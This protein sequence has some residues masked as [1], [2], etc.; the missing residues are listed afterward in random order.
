MSREGWGV[1]FE[2]GQPRRCGLWKKNELV[3]VEKTFE[4]GEMTEFVY[5]LPEDGLSSPR[6]SYMGEYLDDLTLHFPRH[7]KGRLVNPASGIVCWYG[8]FDKGKQVEGR[9]CDTDGWYMT[10]PSKN[11]SVSIDSIPDLLFAFTFVEKLRICNHS[12]NDCT[13]SMLDLSSSTFLKEV[14]IGDHCF[15]HTKVFKA[16]NNQFIQTISIGTV[17]FM[18]RT[19]PSKKDEGLFLLSNLT[20]LV[21]V[22]VG[23]ESFTQYT[24]FTINSPCLFSC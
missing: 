20:A 7:G 17:C 21:S 2:N 19:L 1:E 8:L 4:C 11:E 10:V 16:V 14:V 22:E 18:P 23:A 6:V 9:E 15:I 12:C 3:R 5:D 24:T 13:F